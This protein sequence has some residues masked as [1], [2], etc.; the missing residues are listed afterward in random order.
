MPSEK[1]VSVPS[2]CIGKE[3]WLVYFAL[4]LDESG[5]VHQKDCAAFCGYVATTNEWADFG[6]RWANLQMR[7]GTPAIHMSR[8]MA[9]ADST[10][11]DEWAALRKNLGDEW[12]SWRDRVV[13]EFCGLIMDSSIASV[14]SVIDTSA[15]RRLRDADPEDYLIGHADCNV[16]LLQHVLMKALDLIERFDQTGM[17]SVNIDDD[18]E[19]AFEYYRSYWNLQ[20]MIN[21]PN[22]PAELR[23]R[24]ERITRRVAQL[25]FS[26][27]VFHPGLQAADV[28]A[29][30]SRKFKTEPLEDEKE[31]F[32]NLLALLTRGG[33]HPIQ[34]Y[35]EPQLTAVAGNTAKSI[36]RL[37][38]E[39]NCPGI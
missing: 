18:E 33:T 15:Y 27:D 24:F 22:L 10:K 6:N 5:K 12:V 16:Y 2:V 20:R 39:A 7:W 36:G 30:V 9:P 34:D 38:N 28:L 19:N 29:Y 26:K 8:I 1:F 13:D 4:F 17:V 11:T 35:L 31:R 21:T 37:R 32:A 23:P 25:A 3:R 14:G